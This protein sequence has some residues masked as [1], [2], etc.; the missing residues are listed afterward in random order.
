MGIWK[1][2][3]ANFGVPLLFSLC[4]LLLSCIVVFCS[5][6][7]PWIRVYSCTLHPIPLL[8]IECS[9]FVVYI[10]VLF[11]YCFCVMFSQSNLGS[12]KQF[13]IRVVLALILFHPLYIC[14]LGDSM[15]TFGSVF[16]DTFM[17]SHCLFFL[18]SVYEK[19]KLSLYTPS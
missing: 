18:L 10:Y 19:V 4:Y 14:N 12:L 5:I 11:P 13:Q 1:F 2:R 8:L 3:A 15:G 17:F 16:V 7:Y 6:D 9:P